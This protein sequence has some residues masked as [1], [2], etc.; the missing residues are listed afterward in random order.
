MATAESKHDPKGGVNTLSLQ[1]ELAACAPKADD[2]A[3]PKPVVAVAAEK[4]VAK[5]VQKPPPRE[6]QPRPRVKRERK[7]PR[8]IERANLLNVSKLIVKE[9]IDSSLAHGR[10]LDDDHVPLQQFFVVL[11]HV[12]RHGLKPRK[13]ILRDRKEFWGVLEAVEK[14]APEAGEIT[15]SVRDMPHIKTPLGR[16]RAWIRLALMQKTLADYFKIMIEKKDNLLSDYYENGALMMEDEGM[17]IAGLLVGLNVI[18]CNL[19]IKE[20]DLDQPMGVID[21]SLYLKGGKYNGDNDDS[22]SSEGK[23]KMATILDQK[24]YLEELNRHLN[25]TVTNLQQKMEHLQT[26]NALMKEDLA[27]A[28]NSILTIQ[29]EN[30]I[31]RR[32][33]DVVTEG[34]QKQM[35]ATK[36]DIDVERETYQTNRAGLESMYTGVKQQLEG[37]TEM[38]LDVERE[39]ELQIGMKTEM[40]LAMRLLERDIH[41]KQ[42]SIVTLRQQLDEIKSIN[43]EMYHKLQSCEGSMKHK[44]DMVS[45]L[46]EKTTQLV[47]TLRDLEKST[48][49]ETDLRIEREWRSTLQHSLEE[50]KT[51][52]S[53][54]LM[55]LQHMK[56]I[57]QEYDSLRHKHEQLGQTCE[58]QEKALS[59]L[60]SHLSESKLKVEDMREANLVLKEAQWVGD[61]AATS[62]K[63]CSKD[64]SISRRKH[65]CRNCGDIF[66]NEC[67]DNKMPLPS[68]SKPVRVCDSCQAL[69][70]QR[71]SAT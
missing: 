25:A 46:E 57:K 15:T 36:Q 69:L 18:D 70:L 34:L 68:S 3:W 9:L 5:S 14:F 31:L 62:C 67:S 51:H 2:D 33:R 64:F 10:M 58:E 4:K 66:C 53:Q 22:E 55:E 61:N 43:Q 41:E 65:H 37:E 40:E 20:E 47:T 26:N 54:L 63:Q 28:K 23:S 8:T 35:E 39:L 19:C 17:V 24:N 12:L 71:Y 32:E 56:D 1:E 30:D 45:K 16:A 38:R 6:N 48:A 52:G 60:G 59:E 7:D 42:D 13:G 29:E 49:L 50:E 27:I 44:V 11:E 21:F